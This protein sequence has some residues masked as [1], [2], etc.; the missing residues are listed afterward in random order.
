MQSVSEVTAEGEEEE[1]VVVHTNRPNQSVSDEEEFEREF[2]KMMTESI[3]SRKYERKPAM[4][5]VAIPMHLKRGNDKT[6]DTDS[7]VAFTLLTKK[8]NKQQV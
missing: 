2:S 3:E 1:E 8:G 6:L 5:D 4:L 7:S